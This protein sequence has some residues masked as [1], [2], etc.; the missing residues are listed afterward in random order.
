MTPG[1]PYGLAERY[2]DFAAGA[3]PYEDIASVFARLIRR[4][5]PAAV[6][7]LEIACGSGNLEVKNK[8]PQPPFIK[9]GHYMGLSNLQTGHLPP[10][11]KGDQRGIL[12]ALKH[13]RGE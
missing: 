4:F 8:S 3:L 11:P 9:G 6:R 2:R 10:L 1:R 5:D 7:I 13:G 12:T